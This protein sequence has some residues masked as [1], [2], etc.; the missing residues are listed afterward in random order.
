MVEE[1]KIPE[2]AKESVTEA[3]NQA[4]DKKVSV[5]KESVEI[6]EKQ[7]DR[8]QRVLDVKEHL[9]KE[10]VEI[11]KKQLDKKEQVLAMKE[12][13]LK[14]STKSDLES[15]RKDLVNTKI[16]MESNRQ[17]NQIKAKLLENKIVKE[18][19]EAINDYV[20]N[21]KFEKLEMEDREKLVKLL[22]L[23]EEMLAVFGKKITDITEEAD[24]QVA[25]VEEEA[26]EAIEELVD[27]KEALENENEE[28]KESIKRMEKDNIILETALKNDITDIDSFKDLCES[29]KFVSRSQ[30]K[31]SIGYLVENV[32]RSSRSSRN[33]R[34]RL[35]ERERKA[36]RVLKN[37]DDDLVYTKYLKGF[38][39]D[40]ED[41]RKRHF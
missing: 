27:E 38:R 41:F 1:I 19:E 14:E 37:V 23:F 11:K 24:V 2:S 17:R 7:L 4:V 33:V 28:L 13:L 36:E 12:H 5:I 26:N 30:F 39:R 21:H 40:L 25:E 31:K 18:A 6:K 10:S 16:K 22:N 3:F 20:E 15:L 35:L 9:M 8:K 32:N 34:D 29:V